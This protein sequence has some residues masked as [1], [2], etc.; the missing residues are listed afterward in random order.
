M[1]YHIVES[2]NR[3]IQKHI[4]GLRVTGS[5]KR[6]EPVIYELEYVCKRDLQEIVNEFN[7]IYGIEEIT[8]NPRFVN[9][10]FNTDFGNIVINIWRAGDNYEYFYKCL[11]HDLQ[12]DKLE[13]LKD[14][15]LKQNYCLDD[16][17]F[18]N[19]IGQLLYIVN[20]KCLYKI[21]KYTPLP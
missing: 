20:R 12:N 9:F 1:D 3:H 2:I 14:Q 4:K 15:A 10:S 11:I 5:F 8:N 18:K 7:N 21:I 19:T 6:K 13:K 17:G 16:N